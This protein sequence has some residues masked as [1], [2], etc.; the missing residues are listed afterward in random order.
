MNAS[1]FSDFVVTSN[2][3][4]LAEVALKEMLWKY[5]KVFP[6]CRAVPDYST[7]VLMAC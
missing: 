3:H 6:C 1:V 5:S 7:F 2:S 4:T